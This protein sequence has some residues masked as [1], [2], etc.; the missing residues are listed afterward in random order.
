MDLAVTEGDIFCKGMWQLSFELKRM[1]FFHKKK[2]SSKIEVF[3]LQ[4]MSNGTSFVVIGETVAKELDHL[5]C[6][7]VKEPILLIEIWF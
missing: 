7:K 6:N 3:L 4:R 1:S 2:I 5:K